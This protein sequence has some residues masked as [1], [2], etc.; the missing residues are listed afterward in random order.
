MQINGYLKKGRV[1]VFLVFSILLLVIIFISY[2]KLSV[3]PQA[4]IAPSAPTVERGSIVDRNGKPVAVPTRFYHFG[5][6]PKMIND[7][8]TFASVMAPVLEMPAEEIVS[9]IESKKDAQFTFIKK[10]ITQNQYDELY[11]LAK[12][13]DWSV[14]CRFDAIPWRVYPMNDLASQLI[15]YMGTEQKGWSGIELS[16]QELLSPDVSTAE[17]GTTVYGKNIY[18]TID[19]N[20]QYKLE[21]IAKE[22]MEETQAESF[23]LIACDAKS[24]EILSYISLPSVNLNDYSSATDSQKIDRPAVYS[25]EPGSVIKIFT[26]ASYLDSGVITQD[27]L[28]LCDGLYTRTTGLNE[29]INIHC[30]DHHGYQTVRGALELSC[31]DVF[32]QM[33]DLL[34]TDQ[35][36]SYI[37]KFGFGSITGVELPYEEDGFVKSP[38]DASWS[39]RTKATMSIG[40]ELMVTAL[41]MVQAAGVIA[42]DGLP[43]KLS[44]IKKITDKD[45]NIEYT[46]TPEY[47]NRV[48]KS[49][50]ARYILSCMETTAEK[51][52]GTKAALGDI[53]IG[54]KT[55]TAQMAVNGVYSDTDFISNCMAIF[56]IE[57]PQI[58]LYIVIEK[59]KGETYAGRIVAPVIR[60][61]ADEII[62]HLGMT[63]EGAPALEHSGMVS[64]TENTPITMGTSVPSFIGRPKRDILPL[65][66]NDRNISFIFH[67]EGWVKAQSPEPGTPLTENTTIELYLE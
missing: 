64:I 54:V 35:F 31:N 47:G 1:I 20:L 13:N 12:Q 4:P 53:S 44:F 17:P 22:S 57:D 43:L 39:A 34:P 9:I 14:F 18:L 33:S 52:T 60:I 25:Y 48:L 10:K 56:P 59:A 27:T 63:R 32:A 66:E 16:Q 65:I 3:K 11:E 49:S 55:G 19:A 15:G 62:D 40:Q 5:V 38:T 30:L 2:S 26:A 50:T 42:N 45:G 21:K 46:H 58:V 61:A 41:Q 7:P 8:A 67:G 36:L 23:M 37:H 28:F 51:G 24:G 29:V 6:T